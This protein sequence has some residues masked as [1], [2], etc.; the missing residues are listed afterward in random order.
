VWKVVEK[1]RAEIDDPALLEGFRAGDAEAFDRVVRCHRRTIYLIALRLLGNHE[2]ADE[3]AQLALVRAWNARSQFRGDARLRTWL[4]QI[5]V[6]V[7]RTL[8]QARVPTASLESVAEPHDPG[9][10]AED[11]LGSEQARRSVR[12]AVDA[13]PPR[14]REVV[15][16]KVFSEM[17][18]REV[19]DLMQ[20]SEGAVKAHLHQA[21]ANLRRIMN[22]SGE[23]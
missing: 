13:L 4:I 22:R 19:A 1:P 11:R 16:L 7:S 12:R 23:G 5:V 17:K 20:L 6:N 10:T 15:V 14:Q 9:V 18:H 8:L 21:V 2:D 3:A